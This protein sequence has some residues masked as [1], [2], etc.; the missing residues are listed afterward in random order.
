MGL[1]LI[2]LLLTLG[3]ILVYLASIIVFF[4]IVPLPN[5]FEDRMGIIVTAI[6]K[7]ILATVL[8]SGFILLLRWLSYLFFYYMLRRR[9]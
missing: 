2:I 7:A 5:L 1:K 3:W 9:S 6:I 4:F 8:V